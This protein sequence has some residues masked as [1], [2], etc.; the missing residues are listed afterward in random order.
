MMNTCA[1]A[2]RKTGLGC[3]RCAALFF[4]MG[5]ALCSA[6]PSWSSGSAVD[7]PETVA[8]SALQEIDFSQTQDA[9]A[10]ILSAK[11]VDA[12]GKAAA[13][14]KV[15]GYVSPQV[16]IEVHLPLASDWNG[17]LITSGNGGW[18][19][20]LDGAVCDRHLK[21]GYA[22]VT[23]DTGHR[24][25]DGLWATNNLPAQVDFGFR[26]IH[27]ATLAAKAVVSRY[28]SKA[29]QRAYFMGCSTGGYQGLV[30]A[31]RFPWDFDGIIAGAPDMDEADLTMRDIWAQKSNL[32]SAGKPIIDAAAREILHQAALEKCDM[33]DGVKD[34]IVGNPLAC[35]SDPAKLLC[36]EGQSERCLTAAQVQAAKHIYDGPPHGEG[37]AVRGA[38]AG[39]ELT[40]DFG[41]DPQYADSLF[42]QMIYGASAGWSTA[43]YDFDR[44][45]KRLGLAALY[46]DTNPDLRRYKAAG[47]KLLVYQGGTDTAEMPTAIVDYYQTVEKLMGGSEPTQEFF[48]L[49]MIPGMNHCGGGSGAYSIDYLTYLENWVE[50]GQVPEEMTGAHISD[51]YLLSL[52][53]PDWLPADAPK[54]WRISAAARQMRF[55]LG[56]DIPLDFTRPMYPYP[57]FAKYRGGDPNKAE[58][59]RPSEP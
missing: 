22:C 47:G 33:Y 6:P 40:W 23:T 16:G 13:Y 30:E 59:F 52:P 57:R 39:S 55:P 15:E 51:S 7:A 21:R 12:S 20:T 26:A 27:V 34:G 46:T 42:S 32:D 10:R 5:T 58:S 11:F 29:A 2:R 3:A 28:Y 43:T 14:C 38:L 49:F 31:Q 35:F 37:K 8:C 56:R 9:P 25:S 54:D 18:A 50:K 48:R 19:G 41:S 36:K 1:W 24:G 53:L 4:V 44:D 17:K 45:Y